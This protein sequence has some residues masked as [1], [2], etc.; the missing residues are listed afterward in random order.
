MPVMSVRVS[1]E[2]AL[3]LDSIAKTADRSRSYLIGQAVE[4]L[5][6]EN[7]WQVQ[8]IKKAIQEADRGDFATEEEVNNVRRKW[9]G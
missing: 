9:L 7:E 8:E 2:Q 6:E 4:Q 5:L 1:D 3:L